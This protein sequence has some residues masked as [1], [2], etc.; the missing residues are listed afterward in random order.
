MQQYDYI[1]CGTG[2]SASLLLLQL[3]Q[4]N[5]LQDLNILLIDPD[6][7]GKK[8]KTFCFWADV[9]E[10]I[11]LDLNPLISH[12]W[13]KVVLSGDKTQSILPLQYNHVSSIDLYN[14]IHQLTLH[15]N[16][17]KIISYVDEVKADKEGPFII[18]NGS[19]LRAKYIFDSR[20]PVYKTAQVRET[21]IFQSFVGWMI[22]TENEIKDSNAFRFMDFHIEQQD[23]TQ[24]VYVLPFSTK[25]ALVE[26][27]RFGAEKMSLTD[28]EELLDH[29]VKNN[30]GK[31][32][33]QDIEIG[34]IPMSNTGIN[35]TQLPGIVTMGARNYQIKPSTGYA[36]KNMYY[37]ARLIVEAIKQNQPIEVFNK[38]KSKAHKGRFSFYDGLL[39]DILKDKPKEGKPIFEALLKNVEVKKILNFLD[40]KTDV[41]T[42]LSIFYQLPWKVFVSTL[43]ERSFSFTW[44]RPLILTF[45]TIFF[46]ILSNHSALQNYLAYGLIMIGLVT[47]GIPHGAVDHLL[48]TGKWNMKVAPLFIAKYLFLA[49][50][51]GLLWYI[52]PFLALVIFLAYSSW[53]F[54]QADGKK[55]LLS[56]WSS[57]FWGASVLFYILGTHLSETNKILAV[58][59]NLTLPIACPAWLLLPWLVVAIFHKNASFALTV[60]WLFLSA[61][62]PLLISFGLYFI[63]QHS[64]TGWQDVRNHLKLSNSRMWIHSLPFHATAWIFLLCFLVFW[65]SAYPFEETKRWAVFFIFI[66]CISFPHVISI[67]VVYR[68]KE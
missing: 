11:S 3:H 51:M 20:P 16:W 39:L 23:S 22:E 42:D 10:P 15:Y 14:Q 17:Q 25:T 29:Y 36:F 4:N 5:L 56:K 32:S 12:R 43:F 41:A 46:L 62:L 67:N 31:Y 27:T 63:G 66:A 45:I 35:N 24:F 61:Y 52:L 44:F 9:E 40:E 26:V 28:A 47:V 37:Q 50:F 33:I 59:G 18:L 53:H 21:H 38:S 49:S 13:D 30:F 57:T 54:G 60:F 2:A 48:E 19:V 7:K 6:K 58:M 8:D 34:C 55:W 65:S 68:S 1:F 64:L